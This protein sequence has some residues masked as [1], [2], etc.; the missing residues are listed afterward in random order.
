MK[1]QARLEKQIEKMQNEKPKQREKRLAKIE[2]EREESEQFLQEIT[3]AFEFRLIGEEEIDGV[4]THVISAEPREGYE[5]SSPETKVL[6][7]VRGTL[8]IA[9]EDNAW[10]KADMETIGNITWSV[11]FKLHEGARVRFTQRRINDEVW[12]PDSWHVSMKAK[13]ALVFK[14]NGEVTGTYS[15]YRKFTTDSTVI[16]GEAAH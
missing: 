8:W 15:D 5:P 12:L 2:K 9:R 3:R 14:F 16:H 10:V 4:A 6:P 7:K 13:A 11:I 1:E